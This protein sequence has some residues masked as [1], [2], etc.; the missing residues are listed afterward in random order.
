LPD[1][2]CL[3]EIKANQ[4]QIQEELQFPTGYSGLYFS[5]IRKGYSGVLTFSKKEIQIEHSCGFDIEKFDSEGRVIISHHKNFTLLNVYFPNGQMSDERLDYKLDFYENLF[6]FV[7]NLRK[8]QPNILI[9]G[10]F[11]IAHK[12]IDLTHPKANEKRSGFLPIE[13]A[14]LDRIISLGYVDI[15]REFNKDSHQ[16]T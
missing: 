11:N 10:D 6:Q 5:A 12:P 7:E 15:F 3:Q 16:Y 14:E 13:R 1:I 4:E 8:K 9:C 2:I